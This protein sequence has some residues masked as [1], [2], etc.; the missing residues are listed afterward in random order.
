[1]ADI[2]KIAVGGTTYNLKDAQ[3][4]V[5]YG[6][7]TTY[8]SVATKVVTIDGVTELF[9]GLQIRVRFYY[10]HEVTSTSA[11]LNV[12]SLGAY[13]IM[14]GQYLLA[15]PRF[16]WAARDILDLVLIKIAGEYVWQT[17]NRYFANG[18]SYGIVYLSDDTQS[19]SDEDGRTAATPYAVKQAY[20]LAN[21]AISRGIYFGICSTDGNTTEKTVT[22]DGITELFVGLMIRVQFDNKHTGSYAAYLNVNSLG[23][24]KIIRRF[25]TSYVSVYSSRTWGDT[26]VLDLVCVKISST[27]YGWYIVGNGT[28]GDSVHGLVRLS[29]SYSLDSRSLAGI[30]A[31]PYAVKQT[32]DLADTAHNLYVV[33]IPSFSSLGTWTATGVTSSHV[34]VKS[35][36]S[37][38]AAQVGDWTVTTGADTITISGSISGTTSLT[39]YLDLPRSTITASSS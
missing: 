5:F 1:M 18:D 16:S 30:A 35:Y 21:T 9:E 19:T 6:L 25:S 20:D 2:S 22:I 10:A 32:Y 34:V 23:A 26:E 37:N 14:M 27:L 11:S 13:G 3:H 33:T 7:C 8:S 36:L 28:A 38:P 15:D 39:L 24:C 31:T 29:D 4:G 17:V 12:N